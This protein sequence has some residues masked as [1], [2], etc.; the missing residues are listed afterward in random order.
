MELG[1]LCPAL[2]V[3]EAAEA[4]AA[5]GVESHKRLARAIYHIVV[6]GGRKAG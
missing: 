2:D 1:G 6:T 4:V 3:G 5:R